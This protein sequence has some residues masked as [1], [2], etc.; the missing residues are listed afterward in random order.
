V[1]DRDHHGPAQREGPDRVPR[2]RPQR[3]G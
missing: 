1:G 2:E 3:Q